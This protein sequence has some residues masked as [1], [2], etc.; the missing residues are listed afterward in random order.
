MVY[1]DLKERGNREPGFPRLL[2][3][4][5]GLESAE[6]IMSALGP[7]IRTLVRKCPNS[8]FSA[9]TCFLIVMQLITRLRTLHRMGYVHNDI[10]LENIVVGHHDSDRLYLIDF[11]LSTRYHD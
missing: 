4:K 3:F 5:E 11:G 6:I 2:S 9:P 7:N 10:K 1:K 8:N